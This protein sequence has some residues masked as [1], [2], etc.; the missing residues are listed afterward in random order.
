MPHAVV[1]RPIRAPLLAHFVIPRACA[2]DDREK[3]RRP[4]NESRPAGPRRSG[5]VVDIFAAV[6]ANKK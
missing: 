5:Q 4:G 2:G 3:S 1:I 6:W